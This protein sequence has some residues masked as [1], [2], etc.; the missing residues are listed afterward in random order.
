MGLTA[1]C[2]E[3]K[4]LRNFIDTPIFARPL[5]AQGSSFL[6][7]EE[8]FSMACADDMLQQPSSSDS[9]ELFPRMERM[10]STF[11]KDDFHSWKELFP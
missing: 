4:P 5:N 8:S 6:C 9:K 1:S 3:R 7:S 11:G 10:V 2:S